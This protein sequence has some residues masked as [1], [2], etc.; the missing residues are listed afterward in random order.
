MKEPPLRD[1]CTCPHRTQQ[2]KEEMCSKAAAQKDETY[3]GLERKL[4]R[5]PQ[6]PLILMCHG[7]SPYT[8]QK[9]VCRWKYR[10]KTRWKCVFL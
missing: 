8:L 7:S 6:E 4:H 9:A 10:A 1:T 5:S 3:L 2:R